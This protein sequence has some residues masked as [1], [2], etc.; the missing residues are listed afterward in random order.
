[1][2]FQFKNAAGEK[3]R[4]LTQ[5]SNIGHVDRVVDELNN[6]GAILPTDPK[7]AKA[8]IE[9]LVHAGPRFR[10]LHVTERV[11]WAEGDQFVFPDKTLSS[12]GISNVRHRDG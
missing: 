3:K 7:A 6:A 4:I 11:G 12:S 1:M 8:L 9:G 5:R 2:A 10:N